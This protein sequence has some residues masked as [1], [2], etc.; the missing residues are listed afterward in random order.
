MSNVRR[1]SL[2]IGLPILAILVWLMWSSKNGA[3]VSLPA[4]A[5]NPIPVHTAKVIEQDVPIRVQGLG[6]VQAWHTVTVRSRVDGRLDQ[7]LFKEG[8]SVKQGQVLVKLDDRAEQA[9]L[10]AAKAQKAKNQ[11]LLKNARLDLQRY[12]QL[13]GQMAIEKQILDTQRAEVDSL[14]AS[15]LSDQASID[16]ANAELDYTRIVSPIDGKTGALL[17]DPGNQIRA[18]ES[19]GVVIINQI[20]PIAV[21]FTVPDTVFSQVQKAASNDTAL[22]QVF[23]RAEQSLLAEGQLVLVDN[24]IDTASATL[25]LKAKFDNSNHSLWPGLSVDV[26]L[27]LGSMEN[28]LV[29]PEDAVQRGAQGLYV[30]VVEEDSTI[31]MQPVNTLLFQDGIAV[32]LN[33][34]EVG[35]NIVLDNQ[36]K[37]SPG[38]EVA[39]A[40]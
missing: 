26:R 35:Q 34:L 24:Q 19:D 39:E 13:A 28:A 5:N 36:Y 30:Y 1:F 25:K 12:E 16:M 2:L 38:M 14:A 27:I 22:V 40:A 23:D 11:A 20:D 21:S 7:V 17:I 32:I 8:D 9:N 10:A 29:V 3:D 31:R 33:G 18:S 15:L 4:A 6:L 37:L